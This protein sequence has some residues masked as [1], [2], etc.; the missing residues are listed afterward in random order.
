MATFIRLN[1]EGKGFPQPVPGGDLFDFFQMCKTANL[2]PILLVN[3]DK[4]DA[5]DIVRL[6]SL[7]DKERSVDTVNLPA[8]L[9]V[10]GLIN[11]NKPDCYQGSDFYSRFEGTVERCPLTSAQLESGI[12]PLPVVDNKS[13]DTETFPINLYHASN[14]K[15]RLLG[16]WVIKGDHFIFEEGLLEKAIQSGKPIEIQNGLWDDDE[17]VEFWKQACLIGHIKPVKQTDYEIK[18]PKIAIPKTLSLIKQDGYDWKYADNNTE[19]HTG[20]RYQQDVMTLNPSRLSLFFKQYVC[21]NTEK[22]LNTIPGIIEQHADRELHVNLTRSLDEDEWAMF[23]DDCKKHRITLHVHCA[24]SVVLPD[25]LKD[26]SPAHQPQPALEQKDDKATRVIVSADVDIAVA[27]LVAHD[28][29]WNIIDISECDASRLIKTIQGGFNHELMRFEFTETEL[30]LLTALKED[31]DKDKK[32]KNIILKGDFSDE[33]CDMLAPLLIDRQYKEN[34][35]GKLVLVASEQSQLNYVA[36]EVYHVDKEKKKNYLTDM[37]FTPDEIKRVDTLLNN[38]SASRLVARLKYLRRPSTQ[39]SDLNLAWQGIV[40]LPP[41]IKLDSFDIDTS[42]RVSTAF[43]KARL[44]AID[45]I[46]KESPFVLLTGLTAVGKSTFVK[47]EMSKPPNNLF[48]GENNLQAW[49]DDPSDQQ[50]ILF[51]DEANIG[52]RHW[53][54]FEGLF[55]HPPS[56]TI[57][58]CFHRLS[59]KHKVIFA[60]NPLNYG[61]RELPS[62]FARHGNSLIFEPMPLAFIYEEILKPILP[63]KANDLKIAKHILDVYKFICDN[64][65]DEV[66]IS[67]RELQMMA[68]LTQS[69]LQDHPG[70]DAAAVASHYAY[71]IAKPLV[72]SHFARKFDDLF[73]PKQQLPSRQISQDQLS[74]GSDYLIT[75]SRVAISDQ[76]DDLLVLRQ[77]RRQATRDNDAQKYGGLGG[78]VLEGEPGIGKSDL[79]IHALLKHGYKEAKSDKPDKGNIF[80]RMPVSMGLVEKMK[81]LLKA[82]NEGAVVIMDEINSSP[83]MEGLLNHLLMGEFRDGSRPDN[84]GFMVVGT[85][86]PVSMAGRRVTKTALARR[87]ITTEMQP[88]THDEMHLI[89]ENKGLDKR[90]AT[91]LVNTYEKQLKFAEENHYDPKPCF[92]DV[93][94]LADA[95]IKAQLNLTVELHR[96]K[97]VSQAPNEREI[98]NKKLIAAFEQ[99]YTSLPVIQFGLFKPNWLINLKGKTTDQKLAMIKEHSKESGSHIQVAWELAQKQISNPL[100]QK[101]GP[102]LNSKSE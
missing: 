97:R 58:G 35:S 9:Q 89:L 32:I 79:V 20:L 98:E 19:W 81:L 31:K 65:Q 30:V 56:I 21:N 10:I 66:I 46:L 39:S 80:Y 33:L 53:S 51:I 50:K 94:Q 61:D 83:M 13:N 8:N 47:K 6:N 7:I 15:D 44:N 69:Y 42:E 62:L 63:D 18:T 24:P 59:E 38:E 76:L 96:N 73:K 93:L 4:F 88:Y 77:F 102:R 101:S 23:L 85:Q 14:W 78:I 45:T 40:E 43:V 92:R 74:N 57:N 12:P 52:N 64:A 82:F 22:T 25:A 26:K 17:F 3:Y 100:D 87:L 34:P 29:S 1:R 36:H 67:P 28:N 95:E 37:K 55:N 86:N 99:Y 60:C 75:Q 49:I 68:L 2:S 41:K 5:D 54:E 90:K 27:N 70:K 16:Q 48:H 72:Q 71:L 91:D 84:P 11:T